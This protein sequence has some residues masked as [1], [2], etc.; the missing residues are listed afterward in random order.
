M[1]SK[2]G[3]P[4][5][6]GDALAEEAK[7]LA[8]GSSLPLPFYLAINRRRQRWRTD[9]RCRPSPLLDVLALNVGKDRVQRTSEKFAYRLD[10]R[11]CGIEKVGRRYLVAGSLVRKRACSGQ[12]GP[13]RSLVL[14]AILDERKCLG[15]R[16]PCGCSLPLPLPFSL[17]NALAEEEAKALAK[18]SSFPLVSL[19]GDGLC[20]HGSRLSTVL[21]RLQRTRA[22]FLLVLHAGKCGLML[23]SPRGLASEPGEEASAAEPQED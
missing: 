15:L 1:G 14:T 7:A 17:G 11:S 12:L 2:F 22:A 3:Q 21:H 19:I 10:A 23:Q 5:S 8:K 13:H 4:L 6:L 18:G 9:K 16:S 20:S